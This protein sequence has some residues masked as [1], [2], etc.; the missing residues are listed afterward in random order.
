MEEIIHTHHSHHEEGKPN[1]SLTF[2][3]KSFQYL[4]LSANLRKNL[5]SGGFIELEFC[6]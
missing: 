3:G 4:L 5:T 6:L 2:E 1:Q